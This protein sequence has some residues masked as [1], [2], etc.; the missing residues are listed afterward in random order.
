LGCRETKICTLKYHTPCRRTNC[1]TC[2][3]P[4]PN[5]VSSSTS[6]RSEIDNHLELQNSIGPL[7][8]TCYGPKCVPNLPA[9]VCCPVCRTTDE[10]T[11]VLGE[12]SYRA[13]SAT[14]PQNQVPLTWAPNREQAHFKSTKRSTV[15]DDPSDEGTSRDR[16]QPSSKRHKSADRTF[17]PQ[18]NDMAI[19]TRDQPL[20][21]KPDS[22]HAISIHCSK[23]YS[24]ALVSPAAPCW[25]IEY[26]CYE[27]GRHI[28]DGT[29]LRGVFNRATCCIEDCFLP[30]PCHHCSHSNFH[31]SYVGEDGES[32]RL[33][34]Q[35]ATC[36]SC[37]KTYCAEH[38][39]I[40]TACHHW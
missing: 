25:N 2:Q 35:A 7:D 31:D 12:S 13:T 14:S 17:P 38:A 4:I 18:F 30:V 8:L 6:E 40:A 34:R 5:K 20:F 26:C 37:C 29:I 36:D 21:A 32:Q 22:R 11:L 28:E 27:R 1:P 24:F 19:P 16:E 33:L 23:C 10:R 15:I 39:W 3:L 9:D